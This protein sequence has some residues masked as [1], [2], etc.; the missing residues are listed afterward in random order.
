MTG[1]SGLP[2]RYNKDISTELFDALSVAGET[3]SEEVYFS[4]V[5]PNLKLSLNAFF[6]RK[7]SQKIVVKGMMNELL[8]H[9]NSPE[10]PMSP[11]WEVRAH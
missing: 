8:H 10:N 4:P 1:S 6:I 11:L 2:I 7:R 5:R 9:V 3:I